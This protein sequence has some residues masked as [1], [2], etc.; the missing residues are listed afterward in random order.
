MKKISFTDLHLIKH[1]ETLVPP[2]KYEMNLAQFPL[3][4]LAKRIPQSLRMI[5]DVGKDSGQKLMDFC[6]TGKSAIFWCVSLT[7][8]QVSKHSKRT[9]LSPNLQGV[10]P[11]RA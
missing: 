9:D 7:K 2:S 4:I 8:V 1:H 10:T 6:M 3:T 5:T 11:T